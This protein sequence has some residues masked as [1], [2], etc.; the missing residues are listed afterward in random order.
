MADS[1]TTTV[2]K[3]KTHSDWYLDFTSHHPLGHKVAVAQTLL[4]Q[5]DQICASIPDRDVKKRQITG[6]LSSSGYP[7]AQV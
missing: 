1:L 6:A 7:T 3:K 2:F 5:A 4:T